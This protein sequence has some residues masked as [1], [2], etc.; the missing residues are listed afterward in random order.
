[1]TLKA[2]KRYQ[3]T[4]QPLF[5][6]WKDA[7][8]KLMS[9]RKE[10]FD[11]LYELDGGF[12]TMEESR[13]FYGAI[14]NK[15]RSARTIAKEFGVPEKNIKKIREI[16]SE[17]DTTHAEL[18]RVEDAASDTFMEADKTLAGVRISVM[19]NDDPLFHCNDPDIE[20][21]RSRYRQELRVIYDTE[22]A[23]FKNRPP[24]K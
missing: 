15:S 12:G 22:P 8:T 6:N 17:C 7:L 18:N 2:A 14:Q 3:I 10:I 20:A 1:M 23:L 9:A 5:D 4:I 11:Q 13:Q 16:I 19:I 24:K 21:I